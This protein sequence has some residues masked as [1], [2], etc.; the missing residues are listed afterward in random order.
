MTLSTSFEFTHAGF[1]LR[2]ERF[3]AEHVPQ[4]LALEHA[5]FLCP[6]SEELLHQEATPRDRTWNMVVWIDEDL[7]A[8]F[9]NWTVLDEMHLL[10]FAIHPDRQRRG[11]GGAL[12]DWTLAQATA[13]GYHNMNLEVRESNRSAIAL[14][15]SRRFTTLFRRHR[16]YTDNGE[17]A[18]VMLR[19]LNPEGELKMNDE[20]S[21]S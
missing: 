12:L 10:N 3:T 5:C 14:Y 4:V 6:W 16:Y 9:F 11:L 13:A 17:D 7:H 19:V 15:E 18:L 20:G 1:N 8:F 21:G 2:G